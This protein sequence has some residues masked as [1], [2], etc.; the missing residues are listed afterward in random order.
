MPREYFLTASE[1]I[2]T[3]LTAGNQSDW[4]P[5][6][7]NLYHTFFIILSGIDVNIE[8]EIQHCPVIDGN[9]GTTYIALFSG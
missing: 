1:T 8:F 4:F 6:T 9:P 2:C 5:V 3:G 7:Q